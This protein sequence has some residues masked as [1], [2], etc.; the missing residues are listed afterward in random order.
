MPP[1]RVT[2]E[3][4]DNVVAAIAPDAPPVTVIFAVPVRLVTV[5]DDGVPSAPP[6]TTG[7]PAVPTLTPSAVATPVPRPDTPVEIGRP[8]PLVSVTD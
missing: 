6:F 4:A 7:E 2:V 1:E 8:V 3:D 5:P